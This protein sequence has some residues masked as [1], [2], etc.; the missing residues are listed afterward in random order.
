MSKC[1]GAGI[2]NDHLGK[3]N[4][5]LP[6]MNFCFTGFPFRFSTHSTDISTVFIRYSFG[7]SMGVLRY[8]LGIPSGVLRE[9]PKVSGGTPE[10]LPKNSRINIE[11]IWKKY[12]TNP[13]GK[14]ECRTINSDFSSLPFRIFVMAGIPGLKR[15]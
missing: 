15:V 6:F 1:P 9:M 7:M 10:E 2:I 13:L 5:I 12:R 3:L 14:I 4:M 8:S 11:P